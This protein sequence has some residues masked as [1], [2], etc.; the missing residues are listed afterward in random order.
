MDKK[1][2]LYEVPLLAVK[3]EGLQRIG[4][5]VQYDDD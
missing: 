4:E 5:L 2:G 3:K 1:L